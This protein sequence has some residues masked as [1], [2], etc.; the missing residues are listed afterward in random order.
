V[1][2]F[3]VEATGYRAR[4]VNGEVVRADGGDTGARAGRVLRPGGAA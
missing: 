2:R 1:E 3:V 4:V